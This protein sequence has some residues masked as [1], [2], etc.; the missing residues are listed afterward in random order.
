METVDSECKR[1]GAANKAIV[2]NY[3]ALLDNINDDV[4]MLNH[5]GRFVYINRVIEER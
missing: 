5:K 3:Q 4:Y 1:L 2:I